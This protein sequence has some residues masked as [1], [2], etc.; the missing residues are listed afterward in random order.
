MYYS[1]FAQIIIGILYANIAEVLLHKFVLHGLGKKKDSF[2]KFHWSEHHR[3][4]R[5]NSMVDSSYETPFWKD[6][7][8]A[9]EVMGLA[10]LV[11]VHLPLIKLLPAFVITISFYSLFYYLAHKR[12]HMDETWGKK[13]LP[14]HFDHHMLKNQDKNWGV[15]LPFVDYIIKTRSRK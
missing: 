7:K 3:A 8:R 5:K 14:W 2:W 10:A 12:S 15:L 4:A 11:L 9:K 13:W 6:S 1:I